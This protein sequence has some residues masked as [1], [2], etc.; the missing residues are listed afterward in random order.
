MD[1]GRVRPVGVGPLAGNACG[2]GCVSI[3]ETEEMRLN[4]ER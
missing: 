2:H 1:C 3:D 4:S